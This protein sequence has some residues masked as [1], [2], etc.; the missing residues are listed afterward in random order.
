MRA[1]QGTSAWTPPQPQD[2]I[3]WT[4]PSGLVARTQPALESISEEEAT[5]YGDSEERLQTAGD[6]AGD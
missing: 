6:G 1:S 2:A 3:T 4:H 5:G